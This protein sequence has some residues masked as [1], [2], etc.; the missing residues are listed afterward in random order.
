MAED[1]PTPR[2]SG[3]VATFEL[4]CEEAMSKLDSLPPS[5]EGVD[6]R[7]EVV[8]LQA[9]FRSW[10][11]RAPSTQERAAAVARLMDAYRAVSELASKAGQ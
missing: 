7:R 3:T 4:T 6:L 11:T 8:A 5:E 10:E 9:L 1:T 2:A